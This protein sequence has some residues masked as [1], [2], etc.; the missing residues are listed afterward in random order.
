MVAILVAMTFVAAIIID[1][2]VRRGREIRE[3]VELTSFAKPSL[4]LAPAYPAGYLFSEGHIWLNLKPSGNLQIGLD[5]MVGRLIGKVSKVQFKNIGEEVRKGEPIAVLYQGEKKINLFSPVDGVIEKKNEEV[6]RSPEEFVKDAYKKGWF[7]LIKPKN[8]AESLGS[9][10]IAERTKVWWSQELNRLREFVR[11][12]IPQEA[13]AG[14]TLT[15]GGNAID[16][17]V[18][19]FD[20]KTLEEFEVQFLHK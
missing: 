3:T 18:E 8:L 13:L 5:E 7:Y 20:S 10:K 6:E 15:D 2:L 19:H 17:L 14:A 11:V 12:R 1:G 16:G 4:K 9:F